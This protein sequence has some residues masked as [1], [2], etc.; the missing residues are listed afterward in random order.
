L[1]NK[2]IVILAAITLL[3][4]AVF[5]SRV[6]LT[7][8]KGDDAKHQLVTI[9]TALDRYKEDFG[10]YPTNEEGLAALIKPDLEGRYF[11]NDKFMLDP[12]RQK[13]IYKITDGN[14]KYI[15]KSIGPNGVDDGGL[16]DDVVFEKTL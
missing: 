12:W 3:V 7:H 13:I 8:T 6:T 4:V 16:V 14:K 9:S 10:K 2:Y 15:L 5:L 1:I 11:V